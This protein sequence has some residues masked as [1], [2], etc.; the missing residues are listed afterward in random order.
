M[1]STLGTKKVLSTTPLRM[2]NYFEIENEMEH[3]EIELWM[4]IKVWNIMAI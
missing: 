1:Q 3:I 2:K 4:N